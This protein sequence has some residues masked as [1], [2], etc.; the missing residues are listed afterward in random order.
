M[1]DKFAA[2]FL[3][4]SLSGN[5]YYWCVSVSVS[6]LPWL[7]VYTPPIQYTAR[8]PACAAPFPQEAMII[9]SVRSSAVA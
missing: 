4:L 6:L 1:I 3:L 2:L 7:I 8:A 5:C 9:E